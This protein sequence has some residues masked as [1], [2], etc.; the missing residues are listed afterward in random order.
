M[1]DT[2]LPV[3]V[4]SGFLG[5]GK[6]TLLNRVLNNREGRRLADHHRKTTHLKDKN[7]N[8]QY[9]LAVAFALAF[10]AVASAGEVEFSSEI[11]IN[12]ASSGGSTE[13][14]ATIATE[15]AYNGFFFGAEMETLYKDPADDVE[16]T[17][18]LGY[19]FDIGTDTAVTL[20]YARIYLDNSGF[21]SHEIAAALDFPISENVSATA[22]VVRDLT[23]K[24]TDISLGAE[25]GLGNGFT[26]GVLA[27]HDGTDKYA[28]AGLSYDIT[29]N[30]S[31]GFL[32]EVA[33]HTKPTYN[34][35]LTYSF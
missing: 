15:M 4:L 17:L 8:T 3:T 7:M 19:S 22:E 23:G 21:S 18:S 26:G 33:E 35:G 16:V 6:T 9:L 20:S 28:E 14:T 13:T 2:R 10:P 1:S 12:L 34:F 25:F 27:G 29:D 24:S 11:G 5:A 31:A 30:V 32:V